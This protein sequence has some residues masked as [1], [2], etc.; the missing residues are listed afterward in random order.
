MKED[1]LQALKKFDVISFDIFDTAILR[2]YIKPTDVFSHIER[3]LELRNFA[4]NRIKAEVKARSHSNKEEIEYKDI[5]LQ[6]N[7]KYQRAYEFEINFEKQ[8]CVRNEEVYSVYETALKEN[9]IIMFISDMYLPETVIKEILSKNGYKTYDFLFL[10]STHLKT[11]SS[12]AL[13]DIAIKVAEVNPEAVLHIGDNKKS[14]FEKAKSKGINSIYYK[15]VIDRFLNAHS[16]IHS[17]FGNKTDSRF[18]KDYLTLS[19]IIGLNSIIWSENHFQ[20]YWKKIG[21]LYAAPFMYHFTRWVYDNA[22][23]NG[24]KNIAFAAR[25]GYNLIKIFNLFDY[26]K[27]FNSRYVYLPRHVSETCN[28][29]T[30]E[31]LELFF[32]ELGKTYNSLYS[33][34]GQFSKDNLEIK[35]KWEEFA[36]KKKNFT[37][38]DLKNFIISNQNDFIKTSTVRRNIVF[39]YINQLGLFKTDLIFVDSATMHS[40]AQ[41]LL[42]KLI[43]DNN[44]KISLTGYYY[45]IY[46]WHKEIKQK[47]LRP[48]GNY[49]YKTDAWNLMEFFMSSP[50]KPIISIKKEGR[51]FKPE[52]QILENNIHEKFRIKSYEDVSKGILLFANKAIKTFGNI[53]ILRDID[54]IVLHIN[55]LISNPTNEDVSY[56]KLLRHSEFND[57]NYTPIIDNYM[58]IGRD[59]KKIYGQ[60]VQ[61]KRISP[62]F[63]HFFYGGV[64]S[65]STDSHGKNHLALNVAFMNKTPEKNNKAGLCIVKTDKKIEII[66]D[67]IY[68]THKFGSFLRYRPSHDDIVYNKYD[69]ES[70]KFVSVIYNPFKNNYKIFDLPIID[71]TSDG[72]KA[73]CINSQEYIRLLELNTFEELNSDNAILSK[74]QMEAKKHIYLLNLE[75]GEYKCILNIKNLIKGSEHIKPENISNIYVKRISL[76]SDNKRFLCSLNIFSHKEFEYSVDFTSDINGRNVFI[77]PGYPD[78]S[79]WYGKDRIL[80]LGT[81]DKDEP[82]G[83]K[84]S[85]KAQEIEDLTGKVHEIKETFFHDPAQYVFSPDK[86]YVLKESSC[87]FSSLYRKLEFYD[88]KRSKLINLGFFYSDPEFYNTIHQFRCMLNPR[89]SPCGNYIFFDSVHEGY[90][91][92]YRIK[93]EEVKFEMGRDLESLSETEVSLLINCTLKPEEQNFIKKL[94]GKAK[95]KFANYFYFSIKK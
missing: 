25:D 56:T 95:K 60:R 74:N 27:E 10:S 21:S 81:E 18:K 5:Y 9:K 3:I 15:K 88:R 31:D 12:G 63:E 68:W 75:T 73:L 23:K 83:Q 22:K 72:K 55:N 34:I 79:H 30:G 54:S 42:Q 62:D 84:K 93:K 92:I 14:D 82:N 47:E 20:N 19:I 2:P 61:V 70:E 90:R 17:L 58:K 87:W 11:K 43:T 44:I 50:E 91:G 85:N 77:I 57:N 38:I 16:N 46:R 76:N 8:I 67:I 29:K 65:N 52:Y 6:M 94:F 39:E 26:K 32:K 78:A 49:K 28:I 7:K 1:L 51:Q 64:N 41:K 69:S 37:Y 59:V 71:I 53:N 45:I 13:Y 24:I 66:E 35:H 80:L 33:F 36:R 86:Q 89:W 4:K 40:R 48:S